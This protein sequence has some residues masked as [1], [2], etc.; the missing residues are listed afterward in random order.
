LDVARRTNPQRVH[1]LASGGAVPQKA[2]FDLGV[3]QLSQLTM[4]GLD[5]RQTGEQQGLTKCGGAN[6]TTEDLD[7]L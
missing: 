2:K 4:E 7:S 5:R 3:V 6:R 1:N